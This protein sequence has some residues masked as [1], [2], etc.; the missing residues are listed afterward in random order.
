MTLAQLRKS[1]GL[2]QRDLALLGDV[3]P[4]LVALA[5]TG[6]R[7]FG[8]EARARLVAGLGLSEEEAR[9]VVELAPREVQAG[10]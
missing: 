5:E 2:T 4:T 10:A 9:R 6:R 1:R 3:S 8:P 7:R